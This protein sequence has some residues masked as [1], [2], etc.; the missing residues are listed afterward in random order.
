MIMSNPV[1]RGG[2][3]A[4]VFILVVLIAA[5]L[6]A[7]LSSSSI[8][9]PVETSSA[10]SSDVDNYRD[11]PNPTS[12]IDGI[13]GSNDGHR[14]DGIRRRRLL[15][16]E[17][18][19]EA[20]HGRPVAGQGA[21]INMFRRAK[22]VV[23][24]SDVPFLL[25]VP[26]ASSDVVYDI[27]TQCYG[28]V[29]K[30]YDSTQDLERALRA[31]AVDSYYVSSHDR[32]AS[33]FRN[34][35]ERFHFLST[36]HYQE[37]AALLTRKHKGRVILMMNHPCN[38]A[39]AMY[40][41]RPGT[42]RGDLEGL[43]RHVT[44][45]DYH[46]NWMTR[47][48]ANV[49]HGTEVTEEHFREA[50]MIIENKFLVGMSNDMTET[51]RRRLKLY[52]GWKEMPDQKGCEID[53]I[54]RG[55]MK[56]PDPTLEEGG[57]EWRV[58]RARNHYDMKLYARG[59]AVFGDQKMRV[60]I[61]S[62]IRREEAEKVRLAFGH[63]KNKTE[64]RDPSDI[65][66]FWHIPKASGTTVKETLSSCYRLVRTEMIKPP[67][68]LEVIQKNL[69]LNVD[70]STP[71][72]VLAAKQLQVANRGLAD[73]FVSQL[74][75]E[76]STVFT[77]QH[78]GRAFTIMRHPVKLAASL[79]YYRRIATWEPTYRP[80]YKDLTLKEYAEKDGYYDNW[81]VRMLANAKLGGLNRDHLELAKSILRDKFVVGISDHMDET[82]RQLEMYYG[83]A[84]E[85]EG[86]VRF[87]LHMAPSNKNKY[88]V[89]ERGGPVWT[90]IAEKNK[91]D[92]ALYYYGLE[93]FGDQSDKMFRE[94]ETIE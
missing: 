38:I 58:V 5:T 66:F 42:K 56:L 12:Q 46:D 80:E 89:P 7:A 48:L 9:L 86:C 79:F 3:V 49:P 51:V 28:L 37:G 13:G 26:H 61:H 60:P 64:E 70:L 43:V 4:R 76:G 31:N 74:S 6:L 71:D 18:P 55:A 62:V 88:P 67:S 82:F 59:M 77:G 68:S 11:A 44:S 83:W 93:L 20:L 63:L 39:E 53:L 50:R 33:L 25:R 23:S 84:E 40:L 32:P 54:K 78:M 45:A 29:G 94:E 10:P 65:P 24:E 30:H 21:V 17:V 92:M 85:K 27:M 57:K 2:K 87:H 41:S 72:A 8:L 52:F 15:Q 14:H 1:G 16:M 19:E 35:G 73:V 22:D 81:M 75:L 90:V 34:F 91:Y 47:M 69:V 36:P